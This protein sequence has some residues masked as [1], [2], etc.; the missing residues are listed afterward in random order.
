[1]GIVG[2]QPLSPQ[3]GRIIAKAFSFVHKFIHDESGSY[4]VLLTVLM[5]VLI[6]VAALGTEGA[7][8]LTQH[9]AAQAAADSAA[10]SVAS[11]YAAQKTALNTPTWT[12]LAN[13]AKAVAAT[14]G[15]VDGTN[16][17]SVATNTP[18]S[19][20]FTSSTTW[21][22]AF[23]VIVSQSHAPLLSGYWL[24]NAISVTARA[25]ALIKATTN[26]SGGGSNA[27]CVLALGEAAG[28]TADLASAITANGNAQLNLQGCSIGT[29]SSASDGG[30][31]DAIYFGP[32]GS[33]AINLVETQPNPETNP[34]LGGRVSAVGGVSISGNG[35]SIVESCTS[36]TGSTCNNA[37]TVSPVT[38]VGA[39]PDPYANVT[40]PSA[41]SCL[42]VPT[43]Y[44][45]TTREG[46]AIPGWCITGGSTPL[47]PGTY[48]GGINISGGTVTLNAG[49]YVLASTS[50]NETGLVM[51]SGTLDGTAG[52]TLI[53][54]STDGVSYPTPSSPSLSDPNMLDIANSATITLTAPTT[55]STTGFV[56]M[57]DRL[58]P[59][60]TSGQSSSTPTGTQFVVEPGGT[61]N[62]GGIVY[63]PNG[64]LSF[65]GAGTAT[66]GTATT[67]CTQII[68]NLF[69]LNSSG[70]LNINCTTSTNGFDKSGNLGSVPTTLT[71]AIPLLVE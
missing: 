38:P 16:G 42:S 46:K 14:Y 65:E 13:Q 40:I 48:C 71:G 8:V 31:A 53:F 55:G 6:G 10:V 34:N 3:H 43:A 21:P 30:S 68:A 19:G 7:Y 51:T 41:S 47:S 66:A 4:L 62:L 15:F 27:N 52:V 17:A 22:Y 39:T 36:V 29:N 45:C 63:L 67:V 9:R 50:Q 1:M 58:M 23:E 37:Q 28:G 35:S 33:A 11:Y 69:D 49:A 56:I 70:T 61:A 44:Q 18:T 5:P 24:P 25:V 2:K 54:T 64:A 20:N 32:N 12:Q 59:L 60:G 26:G 57:G